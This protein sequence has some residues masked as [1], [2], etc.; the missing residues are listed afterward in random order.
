[1]SIKVVCSSCGTTHNLGDHLAGKRVRCK[2][3]SEVFV[4]AAEEPEE[5]AVDE[6][7]EASGE[8]IQ[9]A[10][11]PA[12]P[13]KT[14]ARLAKRREEDDEDGK[15]E[16]PRRKKSR[17][18]SGAAIA[19]IVGGG[20]VV[21]L[22]LVI[23]V[24]FLLLGRKSRT[25]P[26]AAI[27]PPPAQPGNGPALPPAQPPDGGR[28]LAPPV[29]PP[30][31]AWDVAVDP[32]PDGMLLDKTAAV[33]LAIA[34]GKDILFPTSP[35][36]YVAIGS[37]ILD[38]DTRT[39]YDLRNGQA[40]GGVR[41]KL[42][43]FSNSVISPDGEY[44]AG[45]PSLTLKTV[46]IWSL[47]TGQSAGHINVN[48]AGFIDVMDFARPGE[49]V[50]VT[51]GNL[52][53]KVV[54]LWD[55]KTGQKTRTI[56]GRSSHYDL[57]YAVSPGRRYL[58][59]F[60]GKSVHVFDLNGDREHDLELVG[61][62]FASCQGLAFSP[63]GTLLAGCFQGTGNGRI[64]A[65]D[66]AQGKVVVDHKFP[67][68]LNLMV[69]NAFAHRG[70]SI[71]WLIDN[72]GWFVYGDTVIDREK[73]TP[74]FSLTQTGAKLQAGPRKIAS[75]SQVLVPLAGRGF[76][77]T[78]S[79][80]ALGGGG[81]DPAGPGT[82]AVAGTTPA[83]WSGARVIRPGAGAAGALEPDPLGTLK[84][85]PKLP[86]NLA[87]G[88]TAAKN[89][90]PVRILFPRP[91]AGQ[92]VTIT[93][94]TPTSKF[95][96]RTWRADRFDLATGKP[97][98]SLDGIAKQAQ[99]LALAA[100][101]LAAVSPDGSRLLVRD[102]EQDSR[103][104]V[105]GLEEKKHLVGWV[106]YGKE[107]TARVAW[108]AFADGDKVW[109]MHDSGKL[110]LWSL[111]GCK[112]VAVMDA[113]P[114]T[115]AAL[116]PGGK[117]LACAAGNG[118]DILDAQAAEPRGRLE[119]S[120][121]LA[122]VH[123][124]TL[125]WRPDGKELAAYLQGSDGTG[126]RPIVARWDLTTGKSAGDFVLAAPVPERIQYCGSDHLLA[127]GMDLIDL[128]AKRSLVRYQVPGATAF[129]SPD[130]R[131][132]FVSRRAGGTALTAKA[133][134]DAAARDLAA[135]LKT[136]EPLLQPGTAV[137]VRYEIQGTG[138]GIEEHRKRIAD[139]VAQRLKASGLKA[140]GNGGVQL[141]IQIVESDTGQVATL[142]KIGGGVGTVRIPIKKLAC[143]ATLGDGRGAILWQD[144]RELTTPSVFGIRRFEG[145]P[146]TVLHSELWQSASGWAGSALMPGQA[147]RLNGKAVLLPVP[148]TL[149]GE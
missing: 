74:R 76:N 14:A 19:A 65:V 67:Q 20:A 66:V 90:M 8:G 87:A 105:W 45:I 100:F 68:P 55:L 139:N 32:P 24:A 4:V 146:A 101:D 12:A 112:A 58:A 94:V 60:G 63:D 61:Q 16:R 141:V 91:D 83:D 89:D 34:P 136:A 5:A 53:K 64:I 47:K 95:V 98:T 131:V 72:S 6:A 114:H 125:A 129:D 75:R 30:A 39:L 132:W 102:V 1:M 49:I 21:V 62:E 81:G 126:T 135:K 33:A 13:R 40:A 50:T 85:K 92:V 145:D 73:G 110:A 107:K 9:T 86:L 51:S 29:R 108:A 3:C 121:G 109:T 122:S 138:A 130:G 134:P 115:R 46:D 79:P 117:Y 56:T 35:S 38:A 97:L 137:A 143:Q 23:G 144:K 116:S 111:P 43:G 96:P 25:A 78:L 84:G 77:H 11:K 80:V 124:L 59:L 118:I 133:L 44:F 17:G 26:V 10:P 15:D 42:G 70:A 57:N 113:M 149:T 99:T 18:L 28:R 22:M 148:L 127:G 7:D 48:Q 120:A 106:P 2:K 140:E 142:D 37:N 36:P 82:P 119:L 69:P 41:G 27:E 123:S 103:I 31:A 93:S 104:D 128:V 54:Q 88:G 71:E 147:V 52:G